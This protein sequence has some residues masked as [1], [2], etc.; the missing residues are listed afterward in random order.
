M[1]EVVLPLR[2]HVAATSACTL[3]PA[4]RHACASLRPFEHQT[5][6][7]RRHKLPALSRERSAPRR[8]H[9]SKQYDPHRF[10]GLG[11]GRGWKTKYKP[12]LTVAAGGVPRLK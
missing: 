6:L 10:V 3:G 2:G 11:G 12:P 8:A 5:S 7:A 1:T 4:L 9:T